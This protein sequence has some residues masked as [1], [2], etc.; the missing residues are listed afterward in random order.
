MGASEWQVARLITL[1]LAWKSVVAAYILGFARGLGEFGATLMIAGN[2]PNKTQTLPTAI[3]MAV[4]SGNQTLAWLWT[5]AI[6]IISFVML[7]A[8]SPKK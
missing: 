5:V 3:Y 6:T 2:I 8:V 7:L 1:P 4:E